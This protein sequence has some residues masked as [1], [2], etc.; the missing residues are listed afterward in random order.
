MMSLWKMLFPPDVREVSQEGAAA[1][2]KAE[3]EL[4][5]D[6]QELARTQAQTPYY[7]GLGSELRR[8]REVNH[9]AERLRRS[10]REA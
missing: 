9:I 1:R 5:R 8:I 10:I 3:E 2:Q 4:I 7:A 6:R